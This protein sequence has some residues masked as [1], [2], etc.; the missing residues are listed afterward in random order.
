MS[1]PSPRRA[2]WR[3]LLLAFALALLTNTSS[4]AA[5]PS[6]FAV[7][8][9]AAR[10]CDPV[11][12]DLLR[13]VL[14]RSPVIAASRAMAAA[15]EQVPAQARALPDPMLQLRT[16]MDRGDWSGSMDVEVMATQMLPAR[17]K[18]S[19]MGVVALADAAAA[20]AQAEAARIE[21]LAEAQQLYYELAYLDAAERL[22]REQRDAVRD[23]VA[24]ARSRY[25]TGAGLMSDVSRTSADVTRMDAELIDIHGRR[26]ATLA[27][28]NSLRGR[29]SGEALSPS[30]LPQASHPSVDM[31]VLRAGAL[32][33]RPD[34]AEA[35]ALESAAKAR[36]ELALRAGR[37]DITVG[38]WYEA[39]DVGPGGDP[40]EV[41]FLI[42]ISLPR[43]GRV[44]AGLAQARQL[45]L[46]A[47][48]QRGVASA[49]V[50]RDLGEAVAR[51]DTARRQ[52]AIQ[53]DVLGVQ[54][55]DVMRSTLSGYSTGTASAFE[56]LDALRAKFEVDLLELRSTVDVLQA[57]VAL[58][59]ATASSSLGPCDEVEITSR[60]EPPQPADP[61]PPTV[62]QPVARPRARLGR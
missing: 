34:L 45:Q 56:V 52:A 55:D 33:R 24:I 48:A 39:M 53:R 19:L 51:L 30:Q 20:R 42:G 16:T 5:E 44:T 12:S 14:S 49:S 57:E 46:A 25:E 29:P 18:R 61:E 54:S 31:D 62:I 37:P 10:P 9:D 4:H 22:R 7:D 15:A 6:P 11:L 23:F 58:V 21:A 59:A 1:S 8:A 28:L 43:R 41:G 17:G 47:S 13:D 40:D 50:E 60:S 38:G 36:V 32:E 35:S 26:T 3:G 2:R 27:A